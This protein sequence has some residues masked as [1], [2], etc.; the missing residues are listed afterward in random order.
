[1]GRPRRS[2]IFLGCAVAIVAQLLLCAI[3]LASAGGGH[4]FRGGGGGG[5][6][7]GGG[8]GGGGGALIELFFWILLHHPA[9]GI[10]LTIAIIIFFIYASKQGNNAYQSSVIR[11]GYSLLDS[12]QHDAKLA[13][14]N[15]AD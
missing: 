9:V 6:G 13:E 2:T 10:P 8:G 1:M 5:H 4:G 14:L 12:R 15:Q 3:A 11:R 7:G